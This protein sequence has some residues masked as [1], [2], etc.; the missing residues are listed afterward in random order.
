MNKEFKLDT[1]NQ[2]IGDI[3]DVCNLTQDFPIIPDSP[4]CMFGELSNIDHTKEFLEIL[5]Q[6]N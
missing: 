2:S 3:E 6:R 4:S 5:E 1:T